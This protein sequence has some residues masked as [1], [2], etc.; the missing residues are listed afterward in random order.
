MRNGFVGLKFHTMDVDLN[1]SEI[2]DKLFNI[3]F[4]LSNEVTSAYIALLY[5][6]YKC[7][8]RSLLFF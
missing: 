6:F 7:L 4:C 2:F 3:G 1:V 8:I 5:S